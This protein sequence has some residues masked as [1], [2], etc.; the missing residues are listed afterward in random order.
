MNKREDFPDAIIFDL[1]PF[2]MWVYDVETLKFLA[3]NK[4][5]IAHYGYSEV[6]FLSMTI[7]D[8]RPV[9]EIPKLLK[10]VKNTVARTN[11]YKDKLYLHQKKNGSVMHVQI[12]S[13]L[14]EFQGRQADLVTAIDLTDYYLQEK[15]ISEQKHYLTK[16]GE[17]NKLLLTS[18]NWVVALDRCFQIVGDTLDIDRIY[19]FENNLKEE[20]TSQRL[21]WTRDSS[22]MQID[23]PDLQN[24]PFSKFPLFIKPLQEGRLFEAIVS[25]LPPSVIKEVLIAQNIYS[26]LVI[27]VLVNNAFCGFIGI[28]DCKHERIWRG[29]EL[30]LLK[31]LSSNLGHVIKE[32]QAQQKLI[33]SEARSRSLIQNGTDLIAIINDKGDYTYVAPNSTKILG[34]PPEEFIGKNAFDFIYEEDVPRVLNNLKQVLTEDRVSIEP[35][36]YPDADGNWQWVQVELTNHLN[37]STIEGIIVNTKIVT[38]EVEKRMGKELVASL[39]KAIDAPGTLTSSL[40]AALDKLVQLSGINTSEVWLISEDK[41]RLDLISKSVQDEN[42]NPFYSVSTKVDSFSEAEGLPGHIWNT[43]NTLIWENLHEH[44]NFI[45]GEASGEVGLNSA[46]GIPIVYNEEFLGCFI[47]FSSY[48]KQYLTDHYKLLTEVGEEIGAVVK[49]KITEEEYRNFFDISPDPHC[50]VGFDGKLKKYNKAFKDILGYTDTEI[51]NTPIFNYIEIDGDIASFLKGLKANADSISSF[52]SSLLTKSGDTKWLRW[53]VTLK[54]EAKIIIAVAKDIT[55]QKLAEQELE[56]AYLQ[57]KNAQKIAKLGY[58]SRNLDSDISEWS[59]EMY[60]IFGY[61]PSNF[62]PSLAN[63]A[64]SFHPEDRDLLFLDP[65]TLLEPGKIKSFE[66]RIIT[67]SNKIRWVRQ[68]LRLIAD[69]TGKAIRLEGTLQDITE[70]KEYQRQLAYSNERFSLAMQVSNEMIWDIDHAKNTITRGKGYERTLQYN[71]SEPL[72]K[73]NSLFSKVHPEDLPGLWES[74]QNAFLDKEKH[75]WEQE[76]RLILE[77][78]SIAYF[79]DRCYISRDSE[80]RPIRSIGS[81]LDV[82]ASRQQLEQIKR[83]NK[84]LREIAWL[85]SHVIR[86]PLSKIMG[87]VYLWELDGADVSSK[88]VF[89][90]IKDAADELDEVIHEITH[91]I[92]TFE[93]EDV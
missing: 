8:I 22:E 61:S 3:V 9:A 19:F 21:E 50:L 92:N 49:Q 52:E 75:L 30:E 69:E 84:N 55:E 24:V 2:P 72:A 76:Y 28:D 83:Q 65:P 64:N 88:E 17:L 16:I 36:R 68:E 26:I 44:K 41:M 37:D 60:N 80:G 79:V 90:M 81:A 82:T 40:E 39:T 58:W 77:D 4:E 38:T 14:I 11:A 10:A 20:T 71:S 66:H 46:I 56:T 18:E 42:F 27:P 12:K 35:F 93:N 70:S 47:C 59:E 25:E 48:K 29:S 23:N 67:S 32:S 33:D 62:S 15:R 74:L 86:A 45:R 89:P 51:M 43:K 57:L 13:N 78:G 63:I 34:I 1:H 53:S 91:K 6:E 73:D 5:A 87:L 7:K 31:N 54:T 85:Q